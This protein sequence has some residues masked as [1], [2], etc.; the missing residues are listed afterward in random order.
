MLV[1]EIPKDE[2]QRIEKL[3]TL[4]ILD[5]AAEERF[6][7]LTRLAKRIF[8]V[9]IAIITLVDSDRQW[10]KSSTAAHV[11]PAETGRDIS[12]CAHTILGEA[13]MVVEDASKDARFQDNP[14][15]IDN[16]KI[17]FYA[18]Y[19]LRVNGGSALGTLCI[20]GSEPR[21]FSVDDLQMLNDLGALAE[22]EIATTQNSTMDELTK[23]PNQRGFFERAAHSYTISKRKGVQCSFLLL[24]LNDFK[25]IGE[26]FGQAESRRVLLSF[27]D[28]LKEVFRD[29]DI[30][31]RIGTNEFAVFLLAS[32]DANT[33]AAIVRLYKAVEA[34]NEQG[35]QAF[36]IQFSAGHVVALPGTNL[37][38]DDLLALALE[39]ME[40]DKLS[41]RHWYEEF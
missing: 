32:D 4:K 5:T 39:R 37:S 10:F 23:I 9:D 16:P 41:T 13:A 19:P 8:K 18:G 1:P 25:R 27:T 21:Q 33:K 6:D 38:L 22:Q 29:S 12:L 26:K 3:R 7:R 28:L 35:A 15:V 24:S 11:L 36:S 31:G 14:L 40:T 34:Y 30:F 20:L 2:K 17:R